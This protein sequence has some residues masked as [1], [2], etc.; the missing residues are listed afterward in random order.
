MS[1]VTDADETKVTGLAQ[2]MRE[3]VRTQAKANQRELELKKETL[4]FYKQE[5]IR[6]REVNIQLE[7]MKQKTQIAIL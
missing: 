6:N 1:G 5:S 4:L 7:E 3:Y 2:V